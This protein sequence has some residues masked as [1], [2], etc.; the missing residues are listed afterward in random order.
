MNYQP[1]RAD[2]LLDTAPDHIKYAAHYLHI[3]IGLAM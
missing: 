1:C 2:N 3:N